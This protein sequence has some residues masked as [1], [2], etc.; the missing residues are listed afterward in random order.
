MSSFFHEKDSVFALKA[1]STTYDQT[2]A[3]FGLRA[4]AEFANI[5]LHSTVQ[6]MAAFG[7][8]N[9]SF[10]G[11]YV[12][13]TTGNHIKIEGVSL[14]KSTTWIG[15]GVEAAIT[16]NLSLNASYNISVERSRVS[17]NVGSAGFK[18]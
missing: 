14:P 3:L 18:F 17:D 13:D 15:V 12:G 1:G 9:L 10:D 16:D 2:S 8:Q 7:D 11:T 5:K 6:H 4:E